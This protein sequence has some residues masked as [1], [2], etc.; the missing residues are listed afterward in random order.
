MNRTTLLSSKDLL[1]IFSASH[2]ATAIYT[3]EDLR[4]E[5]IT[6]AMLAFW[7][8]DRSIIG[9]PLAQAVPE[10]VGQ[11]FI[12]ELH[13]VLQ[14]GITVTAQGVPAELIVD[15][16][17][18]TKYYDYEYRALRNADDRTYCLLHTAFDVTE[19]ILGKEAI[20][21]E[22]QQREALDRE[23]S[24]NEE[25]A[26]ANEELTAINEELDQSRKNLSDLN[27]ELEQRVAE[28][29]RIA[30]A[31]SYRLRAMVMNTPIAMTILRGHDLIVD[32][33]NQPMLDVWR[34]QLDQVIGRGLV[35]IFPEL[36]SQPNPG[37]M[38]G[39]ME[40]GKPF[41]LPETEV[42]LGTVDGELK[43]HYARFSYDPIFEPDGT[44]NSILVTVINI[45]EQVLNRQQLE[46]SREE[47]AAANEELT[48]ANEQL[49]AV[50]QELEE[51]NVRLNM[52]IEASSLGI[53][54]INLATGQMNTSGQF[55]KNFGRAIDDNF[56]YP[57]LFEAMLPQYRDGVRA[58]VQTAIANNSI[59]E[60]EY[61]IEWPDGSHHWVIG[62][63]RPRY[64]DGVATRLIGVTALITKQKNLEQQKDDFLS[65]ASHE[66]KTPITALKANLQ[67]LQRIKADSANP[68][69]PK[70]IDAANRG[71]EK[72]TVLVDDLLNI[73]RFSHDNIELQRSE[74]N[75]YKMLQDS[76]TAIRLENKYDIQVQGDQELNI[77]ADEHRIEQVVVNFVNNAVKYAPDSKRIVLSI[78]KLNKNVRISVQ[79]Q[80]PGI[81]PEQLPHL[82]DRYWRADHGGKKYSGLGLGLYICAEIIER[83]GGEIG[84][85]SILGE[86]STFWFTV[87]VA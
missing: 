60:V 83:H 56:T 84:A 74:F 8:K 31:A 7:G 6:D 2:V 61:E 53:T 14:T 42:I 63:G 29:T 16:K 13:S 40:T 19:R 67:L 68:M 12:D 65:V 71:M 24:L 36:V 52:A 9:L 30:E 15:D 33:A 34:R 46:Q 76:C 39:V 78:E 23:Q 51:S 5:A 47:I 45:T 44:V 4:I 28:R 55:K 3:T 62:R 43:K 17:P 85:D 86:G 49:L 41:T 58:R 79:D 59:Y 69:V 26:A 57:Q 27:A 72:I 80:G 77:I 18:Q 73:K 22:R 66:L 64:T 38:R 35:E 25:L 54:E 75:I 87:P 50:T 32:V 20:E 10:L 1:D 21:R 37:R 82:F 48:A 81:P 70:L 11:R